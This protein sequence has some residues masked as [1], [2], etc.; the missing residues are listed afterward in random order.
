MLQLVVAS[1]AVIAVCNFKN[2]D[3]ALA[4]VEQ[5]LHTIRICAVVDHGLT[6][7]LRRATWI[8]GLCPHM[9]LKQ[10]MASA[11]NVSSK[12]AGNSARHPC[13]VWA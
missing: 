13:V 2:I 4:Q 3:C 5:G 8:P 1:G 6:F 12:L 9:S 7:N 11:N 10:R